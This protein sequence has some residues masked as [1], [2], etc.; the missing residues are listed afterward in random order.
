MAHR[1]RTARVAREERS[2]AAEI[3]APHRVRSVARSPRSAAKKACR[4][5]IAVKTQ[6]EGFVSAT[7]L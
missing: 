5:K 2:V 4:L 3:I 7:T 1:R 6:E